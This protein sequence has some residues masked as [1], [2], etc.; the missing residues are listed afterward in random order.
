MW[1]SSSDGAAWAFVLGPVQQLALG[2][3]AASAQKLPS[4]LDLGCYSRERLRERGAMDDNETRDIFSFVRR[5]SVGLSQRCLL[6]KPAIQT[7]NRVVWGA[8]VG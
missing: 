2:L 3:E 7:M 8:I 4:L 5:P 6:P 1:D